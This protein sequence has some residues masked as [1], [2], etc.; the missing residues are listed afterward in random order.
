MDKQE[1][2]QTESVTPNPK[3]I[4]SKVGQVAADQFETYIQSKGCTSKNT[5]VNY[6]LKLNILN[7]YTWA[8]WMKATMSCSSVGFVSGD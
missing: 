7:Q 6:R 8:F 2:N 4:A 5:Y 1:E 3:P